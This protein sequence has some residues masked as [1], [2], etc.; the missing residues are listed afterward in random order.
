MP[1]VFTAPAPGPAATSRRPG[2]RGRRR[3]DRQRGAAGGERGRAGLG[4][5]RH[6]DAVQRRGRG[7]RCM[8]INPAGLVLTNNHVIEDSTKITATVVAI[9]RTSLPE[10][11]PGPMQHLAARTACPGK[12]IGSGQRPP[13]TTAVL[14]RDCSA[15]VLRAGRVAVRLAISA[16]PLAQRG[17][18]SLQPTGL[19]LQL[20]DAPDA[21][22]VQPV[23]GQ[24]ADLLQPADV[25]AGVPAGPARR[26]A[27]GRSGPP[28]H[29][30]AASAGAA[31]PGQRRPKC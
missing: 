19:F 9:G 14:G 22:Q 5:H 12:T 25:P 1:S 26:C 3:R 27:P 31:R 8:V 6:H 2:E 11:A 23:G 7:R 20:Q 29:R 16:G 13:A 28:A 24:R 4:G 10:L 21:G 30:S 15:P 17:Q 18:L